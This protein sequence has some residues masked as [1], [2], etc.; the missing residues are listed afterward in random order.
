MDTTTHIIPLSV[1]YTAKLCIT[2]P[3]KFC[4]SAQFIFFSKR[5]ITGLKGQKKYPGSTNITLVIIRHVLIG[6]L[7]SQGKK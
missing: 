5:W 6:Q 4:V 3:K 7:G 1:Y 2:A